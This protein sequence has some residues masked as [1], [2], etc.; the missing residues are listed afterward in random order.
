MIRAHFYLGPLNGHIFLGGPF[1]IVLKG[2]VKIDTNANK[3]KRNHVISYD[4]VLV[5]IEIERLF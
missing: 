4:D 5:G 3:C 1:F 2:P